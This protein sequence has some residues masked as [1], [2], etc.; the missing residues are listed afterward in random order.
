MK[1]QNVKICMKDVIPDRVIAKMG[2]PKR[3]EVSTH[4]ENLLLSCSMAKKIEVPKDI[5]LSSNDFIAIG[6]YLAEGTKYYSP[7]KT[8]KHSGEIVFVNSDPN[9]VSFI[10]NLLIKLGVKNEKIRWKIGLNINYKDSIAKNELWNYWMGRVQVNKHSH[11][12]KWLYYSGKI[13]G[14]ITSNT[15][16]N[17]CF[18]IFYSSVIFRNVFLNLVYGVFSQSIKEKSKEKLALILKGFFAGDGSVNYCAKYYRKQVEFLTNDLVLLEQI[19]A[20]LKI[21][22][23]KSIKETWPESTKTHTKALRIY[24]QHDFK[25]LAHYD[26]PNLLT[27]KKETFSKIMRS[28][29]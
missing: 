29:E 26:I 18:H 1:N 23:L 25:I 19:R 15:S 17:G 14:R 12:P 28:I 24:N 6:L 16:K 5:V 9:C 13:G 20:G 3:L 21:L 2:F 10:K 22:G 27:Y 7:N 11:R 4:K 8:F